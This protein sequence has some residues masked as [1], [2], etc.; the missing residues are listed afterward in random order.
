MIGV[1]FSDRRRL[2]ELRAR[3]LRCGLLTVTAGKEAR[4]LR[5][6]MPLVTT[7]DQLH[8]ALGLFEE[9]CKAG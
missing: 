8:D 3:L 2:A 5:H 9:V 6:L 1:E 7:D 4:V